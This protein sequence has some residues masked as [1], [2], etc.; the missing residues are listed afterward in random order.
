[1][2]AIVGKWTR[3][4]GSFDFYFHFKSDGAFETDKLSGRSVARGTYEVL[5][6]TVGVT[7]FDREIHSIFVVKEVMRHNLSIAPFRNDDEIILM[8]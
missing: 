6:S 5:G 7:T 3:K 1:M 8:E 2:N 4:S